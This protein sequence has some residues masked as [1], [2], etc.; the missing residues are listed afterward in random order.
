MQTRCC[1]KKQIANNLQTNFLF[2]I[3]IFSYLCEVGYDYVMTKGKAYLRFYIDAN[4]KLE[5]WI[6]L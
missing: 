2:K 3:A 1:K 6:S 5:K 4:G